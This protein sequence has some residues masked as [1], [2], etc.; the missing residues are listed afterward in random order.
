MRRRL[1]EALQ[2]EHLTTKELAARLD[3]PGESISRV[4]GKLREEDL[5]E[6]G[7]DPGDG[8]K[9]PHFL[10]PAGEVELS[11]HSAYAGARRNP[12]E[13]SHRQRVAFLYSAL[14]A[15][16]EMRRQTNE[17]DAGTRISIVLR[18]AR[19]TGDGGLVIEAL[20]ELATTLRQI[21]ADDQEIRPLLDEL[22]EISLGRSPFT[23]SSLVMPA[24]A[25]REY[26][27]GRLGESRDN[28]GGRRARH[29]IG[30]NNLYAQLA[31]DPNHLEPSKWRERQ[32]WGLIGLARN[33]REGSKFEEALEEAAQAL[34]L[35]E[36][37][38][39]PYGRS[40][41]H[42]VFGDC[43]RLLGDFDGAWTWLRDARALAEEH[44]Y[45]RFQAELLMQIGEVLRCRGE[46]DEAQA[47]LEESRDRAE[48]MGL[49]VTQSFARSA[50][51]AVAFHRQDFGTAKSE[52]SEAHKGFKRLRHRQGLALNARRRGAVARLVFVE[53]RQHPESA[54]RMI[55]MARGQYES[56]SS[57]AGIAACDIEHGRLRLA[58][59][60]DA[61]ETISDLLDLIDNRAAERNMV[62]LDPWVPAVMGAF[63]EETGFEHFID[64]SHSLHDAARRRLS[65][66][67]QF[68]VQRAAEL[69][70][71][72]TKPAG[73]KSVG[74]DSA[75]EM[76][77]ETRQGTWAIT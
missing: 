1:L 25:H 11:R 65:E 42:Y 18:E 63:A 29:L 59:K 28:E 2:A 26:S 53:T 70:D 5:V 43:L 9:R 36:E 16:V 74:A 7:T 72:P 46:L 12:T 73:P 44:R 19:K 37:I 20:N 50:L 21:P 22:E 35:F 31:S 49:Q 66:R 15:A 27:L 14:D 62:E 47:A 55:E 30:A 33:L 38:E 58:R 8:R 40:H 17:R 32:G 51:G 4:V 77:G 54:E 45:E 41:C 67:A 48:A 10:T 23:R 52:L 34:H 76:A 69:M 57:P 3:A 39:N 75:D 71:R 6:T 64:R 61:A 13:P 56:L 24:I 60:K 68:G